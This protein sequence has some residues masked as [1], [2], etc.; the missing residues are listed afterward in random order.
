MTYLG[1]GDGDNVKLIF[2]EKGGGRVTEMPVVS[3]GGDAVELVELE[4]KGTMEL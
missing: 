2:E 1:V 4:G 3:V